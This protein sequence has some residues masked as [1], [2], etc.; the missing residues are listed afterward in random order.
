MRLIASHS[1]HI[2]VM[3]PFLL[4]T[5]HTF[6]W[7]QKLP[8][9]FLFPRHLSP[10]APG[11]LPP[12]LLIPLQQPPH[13]PLAFPA[14]TFPRVSETFGPRS[15]II[16]TDAHILPLNSLPSFPD[17]PPWTHLVRGNN[18]IP[19]AILVPFLSGFKK[20]LTFANSQ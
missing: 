17:R 11:V 14:N 15:V 18:A 20:F 9:P 16:L 3:A 12:A 10:V 7:D 13:P 6:S 2:L 8:R 5:S 19:I 4:C 1:F